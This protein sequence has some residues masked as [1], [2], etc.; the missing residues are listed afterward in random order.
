MQKSGS[1]DLPLHYGRAPRWLFEKM[2]RLALCICEVIISEFGKDFFL[3]RISD[4]FWFQCFGCVLGFDWHSSGLTTTVCGAVKEAFFELKDFGVYVCGGKGAT[5]RKTPKE[6]EEIAFHLSKDPHE[7][8]VASK[9]T[10]KVDNCAL[11]DG[12]NLYHHT[13]IFTDDF[14]WVV[15]QQGMDTS[16]RWARRYHWYSCGLTSFTNE[17]HR[18][19]VS[20]RSFVTMNMVDRQKEA[21]RNMVAELSLRE[22]TKNIKDLVL[23][24]QNISRLP[25]R[26]KVL[27]S[28]VN[29]HFLD[30]IFLK[31]YND[32]PEDF[33]SLLKLE[34]VGPKTI[35][36]LALIS[37]LIY[38]E[39]IS[40]RDPARFSFAHG[41]KDGYPYR[42][43]LSDYQ[44]TID[45]MRKILN[46]ARIERSYRIKALKSLYRFYYNKKV[47]IS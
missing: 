14:K 23:L 15:I 2:K 39:K 4:P 8:I 30:K 27:L 40:F 13:F 12:F 11:Q 38:G 10:A 5:S 34:G 42:I 21:L 18:G 6:I 31:T 29:P 41:G 46:K 47:D 36:A 7:L 33:A 1:I 37:D 32:K 19:I 28:D 20:D 17:P 44:N 26:H 9:L 25:L 24:K 22:P 45:V 3:E 35:R 16:N 43:N